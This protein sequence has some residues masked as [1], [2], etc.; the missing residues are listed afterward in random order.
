VSEVYGGRKGRKSEG[1]GEGGVEGR[2]KGDKGHTVIL[3]DII[4]RRSSDF[5]H[6]A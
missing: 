3:H 4:I 5:A 1:R 2:R 6:D